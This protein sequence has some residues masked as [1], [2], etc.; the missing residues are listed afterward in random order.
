MIENLLSRL[1]KVRKT[2]D[3][4]MACCPAHKDKSP[5][6]GITERNGKILLHCFAGCEP[7]SILDAIGLK[8]TDL[9]ADPMDASK[10]AMSN[11]AGHMLEKRAKELDP[12]ERDRAVL[13]F[14]NAVWDQGRE[15][16]IEDMAR[17][18]LAV[19]RLEAARDSTT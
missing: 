3:G 9:F 5:S 13:I 4:Y 7:D 1:E 18:K 16:G 8:W 10:C 2:G 12:L 17:V 14:A 15:L 6:M 19:D 11:Y